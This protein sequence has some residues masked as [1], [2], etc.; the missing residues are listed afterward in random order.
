[1]S[2][3]RTPRPTRPPGDPEHEQIL[4]AI[5]TLNRNVLDGQQTA[6]EAHE[7]DEGTLKLLMGKIEDLGRSHEETERRVAAIDRRVADLERLRRAAEQ[8]ASLEGA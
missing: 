4:R 2:P 1:M 6:R 7:A 5:E 8:P 3:P